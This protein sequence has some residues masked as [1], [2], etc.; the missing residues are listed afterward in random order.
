M[1]EPCS[2]THSQSDFPLCIVCVCECVL[3]SGLQNGPFLSMSR[4]LFKIQTNLISRLE[5][6]H[7]QMLKMAMMIFTTF[8]AIQFVFKLPPSI[9]GRIDFQFHSPIH[10]FDLFLFSLFSF[11]GV[12]SSVSICFHSCMQSRGNRH[13]LTIRNVTYNDLGNY[14]CQA[15]NNLG[16]DRAS[17][18]LSGI[19]SVCTFDSV[20][21]TK[22]YKYIY[23]YI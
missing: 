10:P 21:D 11:C 15:S 12:F 7:T 16:K 8:V 22:L 2:H 6:P 4:I 13:T 9:S 23:I 5:S 18:T 14:T 17:L 19:P 1:H 20:S 3:S